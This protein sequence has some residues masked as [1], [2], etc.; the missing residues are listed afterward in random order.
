VARV[1]SEPARPAELA[2]STPEAILDAA[3]STVADLGFRRTTVSDVARRAG[4]SRMTIYR[5][6][7]DANAVFHALL[8][9]EMTAVM[10]AAADTAAVQPTGRGRLV[11]GTVSTV[12]GCIDHPMLRRIL[13]IDSEF[14]LPFIVERFGASQRLALA[15]LH[16]LLTEGLADGSIRTLNPSTLDAAAHTLLLTVQSFVFSARI[17]DSQADPAAVLAE[18]RH[19]LDSYLRPEED[20]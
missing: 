15:T 6:Y 18:L 5:E 9:R 16:E 13:D 3:S 4:V 12:A 17:T 19:L 1:T 2:R 10:T 11:E 8:T 7:G 14:L 20:R